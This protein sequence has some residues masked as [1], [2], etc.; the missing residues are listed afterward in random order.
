MTLVFNKTR[1]G[2]N[3]RA[4]GESP[5]TADAAGINVTRYKYA[6]A[7]IGSGITGLAGVYCVMEFK[8]GA[9]ATADLASIQAFGWLSVALVI[10]AFWKPLNL[11]WGSL[12]FGIFY[13]AYL[14]LPELLNVQLS[15]DL[16]QMLPYIITIVVLI[17]VSFRKKKENLGPASL[18]VTYFREER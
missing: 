4:V 15:T 9:W 17:I 3:L 10:F 18:G 2:L 16:T 13:W 5:A 6:A 14:Y 8:S 11:L 7:C 1:T 12:I